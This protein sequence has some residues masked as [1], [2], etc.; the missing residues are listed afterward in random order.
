MLCSME[1]RQHLRAYHKRKHNRGGQMADVTK[2][3]YQ[4]K[5]IWIGIVAVIITAYNAASATF[6]LPAIPEFV[7]G[8]LGA[9]GIYTRATATT[10]IQ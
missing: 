5:T 1:T 6:A 8:I 9:L 4:S 7:F 2:P 10:R 3:W